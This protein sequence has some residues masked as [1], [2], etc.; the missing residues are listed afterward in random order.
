MR[1]GSLSK[2]ALA[3]GLSCLAAL[4]ARAHSPEAVP[5]ARPFQAAAARTALPRTALPRTAPAPRLSFSSQ[6]AP[7]IFG[8]G[9]DPGGRRFSYA[10]FGET[11]G[12][13][14]R[15]SFRLAM[16]D[17]PGEVGQIL[18]FPFRE[19]GQTALFALGITALISVDRQ[20]TAFWQDNIEPIFDGF[21]P[22][23]LFPSALISTESQ[24]VLAGIGL[25]YGAGLALNDERAQTAAL[26][27]GKAIGYSYL[28]SQLILKPLFGRLRPIDNLSA[29]TGPVG[30]FT[31]D[32]WEFG[33]AD[34]IPFTPEAWATAMP[35]FHFTQYFAVA[36]VYA[37][38][39]DNNLLPYL[40]AGVAAASNIRGHHHWVSDMVAGS[41]IGIGIG[42]LVLNNYEERK[43]GLDGAMLIPV[44]SSGGAGFS[45]SMEF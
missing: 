8:L 20:T 18:S 13:K 17:I 42:N 39:Y 28:T 22:Q 19:P 21:T 36:R 26:L 31:D 40:A 37:G 41:I 43:T 4:P 15:R 45:F 32:P 6:S 16:A 14:A 33:Y 29:G 1:I 25:S 35:S 38:I 44:I 10:D 7:A 12:Q 34:S 2:A 30:E 5:E 23:P 3:L 27:S 11:R 24:Y 9:P